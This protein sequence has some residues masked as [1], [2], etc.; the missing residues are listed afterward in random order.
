MAA[1]RVVLHSGGLDSTVCL[2]LAAEKE[3]EVLSVGFRYGQGEGVELEYAAWQCGRWGIRREVMNVD[4][5][6]PT[7]QVPQGRTLK[8]IGGGIAPTFIPARN[9]IFLSIG[10]NVCV[11]EKAEELWIGVSEID[12]SGYPDCR[13]PFIDAVRGTAGVAV[14]EPPDICTP[15]LRAGKGTVGREARRLGLREQDTWSCYLPVAN[16][17]ARFGV[18]ACGLCDACRLHALAWE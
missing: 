5:R 10:I 12:Y 13:G 4:I 18:E 15:L 2:L 9:L 16:S 6:C 11:T 3:G 17:E 1:R 14:P 7:T 8:E